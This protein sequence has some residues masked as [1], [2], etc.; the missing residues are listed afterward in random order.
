MER[1][2][3]SIVREFYP[4]NISLPL[5]IINNIAIRVCLA[6]SSDQHLPSLMDNLVYGHSCRNRKTTIMNTAKQ[7]DTRKPIPSAQ[8]STSSVKQSRRFTTSDSLPFEYPPLN[9]TTPLKP[10]TPSYLSATRPSSS[11]SSPQPKTISL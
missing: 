5:D 11:T 1:R 10:R 8:A 3:I 7:K 6:E 2:R 9:P 4:S